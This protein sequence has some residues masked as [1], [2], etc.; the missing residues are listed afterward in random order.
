MAPQY[1]DARIRMTLVFVLFT[2]TDSV[3]AGVA[4]VCFSKTMNRP[5]KWSVYVSWSI[6]RS[7]LSSFENWDQILLQRM[8]YFSKRA[9]R[10]SHTHR[11]SFSYR[12]PF[13]YY[14]SIISGFLLRIVYIADIISR[15]RHNFCSTCVSITLGW[16]FRTL[17]DKNNTL[18]RRMAKINRNPVSMIW[19][20][21][22]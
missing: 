13:S 5:M 17:H 6:F 7:S 2:W 11:Q 8:F 3:F 21:K 15:Y 16:P 19:H 1:S 10:I 22:F 20:H 14:P 9:P 18:G 4:G 12:Q